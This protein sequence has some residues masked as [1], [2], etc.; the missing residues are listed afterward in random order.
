MA[1]LSEECLFSFIIPVYNCQEYI[2]PCINS[3]VESCKISNLSGELI[4]VDDGSSDK[5]GDICDEISTSFS[6]ISELKNNFINLR[7]KVFH[8]INLG[9]AEARNK[10]LSQAE[11][12]YIIFIDSDDTV[13]PALMAECLK[14]VASDNTID[15][16]I[17]GMAFDYYKGSIIYRSSKITPSFEGALGHSEWVQKINL[18]FDSNCISSLCNKIIKRKLLYDDLSLRKD[19]FVYEDLEFSLRV[20]E[21]CNIIKLVAEPVYHYRQTEKEDHGI[22]RL[23]LL[24]NVDYVIELIASALRNITCAD[25]HILCSL[26]T[27]LYKDKVKGAKLR[28]IRTISNQYRNWI[29]AHGYTEY[30][31]VLYSGKMLKIKTYYMYLNIRHRIARYIKHK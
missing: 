28:E 9:V 16:L 5:S 19:M 2:K 15:M 30:N 26:A 17:Y 29:D 27:M 12:N 24:K 3:I 31:K 11:G 10:G 13:K 14:M 23:R 1:N 6:N 7:C 8:Q 20:L 21:R 22:Q 18:L 25:E 4:L